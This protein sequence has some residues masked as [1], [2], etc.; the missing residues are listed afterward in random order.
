MLDLDN[1]L[2]TIEQTENKKR[3]KAN[4]NKVDE[5]FL[6][7][8]E[9]HTYIVRLLPYTASPADTFVDYEEYGFPSCIPGQG[10]V[11]LG[12]TP[13]SVGKDDP[14]ARLQWS[15]YQE[16]KET[17]DDGK[18]QRSYKLLPQK[19]RMVNVYVVDDPSNPENN[20]TVKVLRFSSRLNKD[21][22]PTGHI[23]KIIES[24]IFGDNKDEVGKRAFD[25]TKNGCN[26]KI[27]V[28]KNAGGWNDYSESSFTFPKDLGLNKAQIEEIY[29]QTKDLNEL[30]PNV[31]SESEIQSILDVHWY[32]NKPSVDSEVELD[33]D[34]D[35]QIDLTPS[36][37]G[38]SKVD[39]L[40]EDMDDFLD[41][42]D[43]ED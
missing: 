19:K 34:D 25:L 14:V 2:D 24:G 15:T 23:H 21:G 41:G 6:N 30:I 31:K 17:K 43:L 4:E 28:T 7:C 1:L 12:R 39:E 36:N 42:L 38:K 5:N 22:S 13:K 27:K 37:V 10:Y 9:G 8:K 32:G 3:D 20:G 16:G 29:S 26:L 11:Y 35:D 33:D 18:M 40:E